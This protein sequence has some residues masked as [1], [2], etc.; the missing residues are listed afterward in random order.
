MHFVEH[1][2]SFCGPCL[3]TYVAPLSIWWNAPQIEEL[4][5]ESFF[6][7]DVLVAY[8]KSSGTI[9][10]LDGSQSSEWRCVCVYVCVYVCVCLLCVRVWRTCWAKQTARRLLYVPIYNLDTAKPTLMRDLRPPPPHI[11]TCVL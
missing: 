1:T 7:E 2:L 5:Q 4:K 11:A 3:I 6:V 8:T 9:T 10:W